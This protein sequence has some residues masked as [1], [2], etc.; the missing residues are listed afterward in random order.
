MTRYS[1]VVRRLPFAAL[2]APGGSSPSARSA[3]AVGLLAERA[4]LLRE[5]R[6]GLPV[7]VVDDR[8]HLLALRRGLGGQG[9]D[10]AHVR[11]VRVDE[12]V[13]LAVAHDEDDHQDQDAGED[14][15]ERQPRG[16]LLEHRRAARSRRRDRTRRARDPGPPPPERP[17]P[18]P[19]DRLRTGALGLGLRRRRGLRGVVL[20]AEVL[21]HG[22]L[23]VPRDLAGRALGVGRAGAAEAQA[24]AAA[25]GL[26]LPRR[27]VLGWIVVEVGHGVP[28]PGP[29]REP[30]RIVRGPGDAWAPGPTSTRGAHHLQ[31]LI[32]SAATLAWGDDGT[33]RPG[34]GR[35]CGS[36]IPGSGRNPRPVAR[37][38]PGGHPP[39]ADDARRP[40]TL[41]TRIRDRTRRDRHGL[42]RR[43]SALRRPCR[44]Q[45]D[46]GPDHGAA[47]AVGGARRRAPSP[48]VDRP[49]PRLG[50]RGRRARDR[51]RP[52]RGSVAVRA[53]RERASGGGRGGDR[54]R[55]CRPRRARARPRTGRRPQGRQAREHPR[56]PRP[57]GRASRTSASRACP[58]RRR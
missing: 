4:H 15:P 12:L 48:S 8:P 33:G 23:V 56:S 29:V 17:E 7:R 5:L 28:K 9:R 38:S 20:E 52:R 1:S 40:R 10:V 57:R 34:C 50:S 18:P 14:E 31:V 39:A 25:R 3:S 36:C 51:V 54:D 22:R 53:A 30:S 55:P 6:G 26:A 37:R 13:A 45:G 32:E 41:S 11:L 2:R 44:G 24:T 19:E 27:R 47:G 49:D 16:R 46:L 35:R 43:G 58:A 21:R 42:G